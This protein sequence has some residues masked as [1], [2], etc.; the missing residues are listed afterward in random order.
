MHS[1]DHAGEHTAIAKNWGDH[2]RQTLLLGIPLI[3]AQL[4]Q[5]GIHTTDIVIVGRLGTAEL[6]AMVLAGQFWFTVFIF[7]SG[8]AN[9][10]VP[11]AA[12]AHG[13]G[14]AVYVRRAVRMGLWAVLFYCVL[15]LP[16]FLF[17]ERILV[18]LGQD[19]IVSRL[20]GNYLKITAWSMVPALVFFVLRSFFSALNKA[21]IVLYVT[22]AILLTNAILAYSLALGHFGFPRM[23]LAGA[24]I[25]SVVVNVLSVVL[26]V[27]YIRFQPM[28]HSY[29]LFIRFWKA[30]W[31]AMAE[32]LKLGLPISV[33]ILA[34][35]SLFTI[36]SLL[37]GMIGTV[38]LAA[39]GIAMQLASIAFMV[40]LGLSQ[41]ATVRVGFA[42]GR[43]DRQAMIRSAIAAVLLGMCC[44]VIGGSVF[45]LVPQALAALFLDQANAD[46]PAVLAIAGPFVVVAGIFQMVDGIQA[47]VS[48]LLRGIKDTT[49][50][51]VLALIS[52]W[53]LGFVGCYVFAFPLGL[54]GIGIWYGFLL[55]LT[56]GA[57]MLS[58]RFYIKMQ[59][60]A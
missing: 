4:A 51:M 33:S 57:L 41:A 14:D 56:F 60:V 23:G 7:G 10:V 26:A 32:V 1:L 47:I 35:V 39:H 31:G 46:T 18:A 21:G 42:H 49:I 25:S 20:A 6:A 37:M 2:F 16:V 17:A 48:G 3:G 34:E 29:T 24:A 38:E 52:Y 9:A 45:A 30:D 59:S 13:R 50:P 22:I 36:A 55:G 54:G 58:A 27:A 11:M 12:Q 40:P 44:S 8:F 5:L 28:L 15:T 53:A 43:K 19:A